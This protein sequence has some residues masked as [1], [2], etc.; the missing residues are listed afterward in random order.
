MA[1]RGW[2]LGKTALAVY[3]AIFLLFLYGPFIVLTIISFQGGPEG[4]VRSSAQGPRLVLVRATLR[5]GSTFPYRSAGHRRLPLDIHPPGPNDDGDFDHAGHA[6]GFGVPP[7][8]QGVRVGVLHRAPGDHGAWHLL[9][10]GTS[11]AANEI[12]LTRNWWS[13]GLFV[14]VVYTFPFAFVVMLAIF[15]RFDKSVEEVAQNLGANPVNNVQED[16]PAGNRAGHSF[17]R[18]L[19]GS[20]SPTTNFPA[21][22]WQQGPRIPSR[23]SCTAPSPSRFI[24]TSSPSACSRRCSRSESC[25]CMHCSSAPSHAGA[26]V[27]PASRRRSASRPSGTALA[28]PVSDQE[29]R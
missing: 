16:H 7:S 12:G 15:N 27:R 6:D 11:L 4:V 28:H 2:T 14:H 26:S 24:P 29:E 25:W 8:V 9:G 10:L 13:T 5:S 22:C 21:R 23:S 18:A 1:G 17:R 20:P 3:T 19:R